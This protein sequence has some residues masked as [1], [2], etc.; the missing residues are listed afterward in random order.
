MKVNNVT[1]RYGENTVLEN[2]SL[3]INSPSICI[4]GASGKG[5]TTLLKLIAGLLKPQSGTIENAPQKPSMMFQEDRLL[6]WITVLKNVEL[7]CD[8][9]EKARALLRELEIDENLDIIS[10]SL[11]K[12]IKTGF[13][14]YG[15]TIAQFYVTNVVLPENDPNFKRIRELHT[16]VL[17][18][19]VLQAEA[20]VR[21]VKG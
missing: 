10:E 12:K 6:P 8:D 2:Y 5:K 17:Q 13:E 1:F 9:E 19:K 11:S 20:T 21:T 15:L 3:D 4:M 18:S 7:V 16:V 14:E